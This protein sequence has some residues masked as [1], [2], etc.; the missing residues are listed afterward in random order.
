VTAQIVSRD[1]NDV[2]IQ[3]T[4][5][6]KP[7]ML[8]TEQSIIDSVN[9]V[10][11]LATEEALNEFDT[12]GTPIVMGGV[13]F[14]VR[15]KSDKAYQTPYGTAHVNRHVYQTSKGGKIYVPL[16]NTQENRVFSR[17]ETEDIHSIRVLPIDDEFR[18]IT[19]VPGI[20]EKIR[21][22]LTQS[23]RDN[24]LRWCGPW[25]NG[26]K[27]GAESMPDPFCMASRQVLQ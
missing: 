16:E 8:E 19:V 25:A 12:D 24:K 1:G 10:G 14:T 7:S 2:T 20:Q 13:K 17:C 18:Q 6:L 3:V 5:S 15:C 27:P 4:V 22:A 11:I 21:K 26:S 23:C 9:Q